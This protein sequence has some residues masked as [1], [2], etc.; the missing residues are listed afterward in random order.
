MTL[1][2]R[3]TPEQAALAVSKAIELIVASG[4]TAIE[5][6]NNGDTSQ[7]F[8]VTHIII[9]GGVRRV[10]YYPTTMTAYSNGKTGEYKAARGNGVNEAIRIAKFG[11]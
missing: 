7:R 5:C 10:E 8:P 11:R 6:S 9:L 4:L 1:K 3:M 2:K